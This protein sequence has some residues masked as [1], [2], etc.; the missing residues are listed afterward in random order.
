MRFEQLA[1]VAVGGRRLGLAQLLVEDVL[2][3]RAQDLVI[4]VPAALVERVGEDLAPLQ[5]LQYEVAAAPFQ[6]GVAEWTAEPAQDA[7]VDQK[8]PQ[9]RGQLVED[10]AGQVLVGEAGARAQPAQDP[11]PLLGGLAPGREVEQLQRRC[12]SPGPAG[13]LGQLLRRPGLSVEVAI[14]PLHLPG[15]EAQVLVADLDQPAV[16]AQPGEVDPGSGPRCEQDHDRGRQ[17]V[18]QALQ[19]CLGRAV[20]QGVEVVDHQRRPGA[21]PGLER[22]SRVLDPIPAPGYV[23]ERAAEGSLQVVEHGAGVAV[24]AFGSVPGHGDGRGRGEAGEER[25]LARSG[26]SDDQP[27]PVIAQAAEER[28]QA[29]A[30]QRLE[31]RNAHLRR[32]HGQ[33]LAVRQTGLSPLRFC[34]P[35]RSGPRGQAAPR[36]VDGVP[37]ACLLL[38]SPPVLRQTTRCP[39]V[40]NTGSGSAVRSNGY[41]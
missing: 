28:V 21:R 20:L 40:V 2:Q 26:R 4:A 25:R 11:A 12:P 36:P 8:A 18:D 31:V 7:G 30:R 22:A 39:A 17:V 15:A 27:N 5:L 6:E 35:V 38:R 33:C 13:Q 32:H 37:F 16:Q 9:L 34:G 41:S 1:G 19:G 24:P 23:G 29:L 10:V 14:Q 3:V